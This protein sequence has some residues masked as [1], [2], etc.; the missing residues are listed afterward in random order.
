MGGEISESYGGENGKAASELGGEM[1]ETILFDHARCS[2]PIPSQ[3]SEQ[4][5]SSARIA[6]FVSRAKTRFVEEGL[7]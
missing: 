4:L 7:R 1:K 5:R 3:R 6:F 2:C